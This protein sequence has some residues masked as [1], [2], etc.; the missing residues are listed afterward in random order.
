MNVNFETAFFEAA[1]GNA[2]QLPPS[3]LPEVIFCGRSNVGKSSLLNKILRRKSLARVSSS[4]GKTATVNFYRAGDVRLADLPGYGYAKVPAAEKRRFAELMEGYFASER[5]ICLTVQLIDMRHTPTADD[6][7][8]MQLLASR[9]MRF[10]VVM[11]KAD[12]LKPMQRK[13]R[14]AELESELSFLPDNTVKIPFSAVTGEGADAVKNE[15][16]RSCEKTEE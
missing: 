16:I 6:I 2:K 10:I 5:Q 3:D 4:P 1:Y 11:T 13:K 8:M 14:L 15:I 12:K 9:G 7:S